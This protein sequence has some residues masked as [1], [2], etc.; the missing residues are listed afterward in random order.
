MLCKNCGKRISEETEVCPDCGVRVNENHIP[1][2]QPPVGTNTYARISLI[3]ALIGFVV[4]FTAIPAIIFGKWAMEQIT[5]DDE[6]S[7]KIAK[8]GIIIGYV[9]IAI[10]IIEIF[11]LIM[12]FRSFM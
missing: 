12:W 1:A 4:G 7:K 9:E 5:E 10:I 2:T 8:A 11:I 3:C 6:T